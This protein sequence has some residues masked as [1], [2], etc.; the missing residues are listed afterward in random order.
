MADRNEKTVTM[1][2][3]KTPSP[4]AHRRNVMRCVILCMLGAVGGEFCLL[5]VLDVLD[6]LEVQESMRC[7]LLCMLKVSGG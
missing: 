7:V 5:E 4:H 1:E 6:V 2:I 3:S